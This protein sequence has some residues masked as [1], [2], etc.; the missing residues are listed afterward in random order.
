MCFGPDKPSVANRQMKPQCY[1]HMDNNGTRRHI[2][3]HHWQSDL[4]HTSLSVPHRNSVV[5]GRESAA[6]PLTPLH[7][8][9]V[10]T[11]AGLLVLYPEIN[12]AA[13]V[14]I[15]PNSDWQDVSWLWRR[16]DIT[17]HL[18]GAALSAGWE[19]HEHIM[20]FTERGWWTDTGSGHVSEPQIEPTDIHWAEFD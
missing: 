11:N 6:T 15:P 5:W 4:S 1:N 19:T 14:T 10:C 2:I 18:T 8:R 3:N 16:S 7:C 13:G 9:V 12:T 20:H 17:R